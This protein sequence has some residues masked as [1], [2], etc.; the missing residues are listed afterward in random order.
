MRVL[1]EHALCATDVNAIGCAHGTAHRVAYSAPNSAADSD[2]ERGAYLTTKRFADGH[3]ECY[4]HG[5]SD[6]FAD[7]CGAHTTADATANGH[8]DD[9]AVGDANVDANVAAYGFADGAANIDAYGFADGAAHGDADTNAHGDAD[10]SPNVPTNATAVS[11]GVYDCIRHAGGN[12]RSRS[13]RQL[14]RKRSQV[15]G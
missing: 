8:A 14:L 3:T 15:R 7:N 11:D 13:R 6:E 2:A 9:A 4:S 10:S 1:R 5:S 12:V